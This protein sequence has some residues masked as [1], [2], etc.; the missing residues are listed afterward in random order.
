MKKFFLFFTR[1]YCK[2][3]EKFRQKFPIRIIVSVMVGIAI[4]MFLSTVT[5]IVL[6]A[7]GVMPPP[8]KPM[9]E[10]KPLIIAVCYH[11]AYAVLAAFVT[12][13]IAKNKARKAVIVLGTKEAILWLL[14]ILLLWKHS[15]PWYNLTKAVLGVP[16]AWLG[17]KIYEIY[18]GRKG[19]NMEPEG[20]EEKGTIPDVKCE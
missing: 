11:S 5:H 16:L 1:L 8:H 19:E 2:L 3:P 10:T 17:G 12:A 13:M 14:G 9:F 4:G 7:V 20:K 15:A 18:K 6:H